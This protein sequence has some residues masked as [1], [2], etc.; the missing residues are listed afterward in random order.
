MACFYSATLAWN[1]TAVDNRTFDCIDDAA[2][3]HQGTIA[4][5]LNDAAM[6]RHNSGIEGLAPNL[7]KRRNR[8]GLIGPNHAAVTGNIGSEDRS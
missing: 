6:T 5:H 3:L 2:K 1:P 8:A 4:H 7:P